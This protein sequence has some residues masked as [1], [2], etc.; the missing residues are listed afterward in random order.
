MSS[1]RATTLVELVAGLAAER[2]E[3]LAVRIERRRRGEDV[4]C[5]ALFA[6]ARVAAA[7]LRAAGLAAGDRVQLLF[8]TDRA[9]I[10]GF[11]GVL[12]AGGVPVPAAP[13]TSLR[14]EDVA[15]RGEALRNQALDA[16][17]SFCLAPGRHRE[18]LQGQL[19]GAGVAVLACEGEGSP[20]PEADLAAPAPEDTAFLQYTSGSTGAPKGVAL[21]HA[22]VLANVAAIED[23]FLP[24]V[25]GELTLSWLPLFHDMGLIGA[26]LVSLYGRVP[27]A[28]AAPA[29]FVRDP[30]WFLKVASRLRATISV[31]PNFA[32]GYAVR[33]VPAE[34]VGEL[35]LAPLRTILNGAE[36][37][38]VEALRRFEEHFA[39]AGLRPGAVRAVYGL[40]ESA[41]AV[42][43]A[44]PGPCVIDRIDADALERD[45][46]AVPAPAGARVRSLVSVGRP[47]ATQEVRIAGPDDDPLGEREVGEVCVRG[48]S[49]MAGYFR[50]PA[51]T[52]K[53]LRA[54]WLR[55]GDFGYLAGGELYLVGREKETIRRYGRSYHPQDIEGQLARLEGVEA[56]LAFGVEVDDDVRVVLVVATRLDAAPA[57]EALE[58]RV[59]HRVGRAFALPVDAVALVPP[60]AIPKSTSGKLRRQACRAFYAHRRGA[61][62]PSG[63]YRVVSAQGVPGDLAEALTRALEDAAARA[64]A[65]E[66]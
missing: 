32:F 64:R 11:F 49:V 66:A 10:E 18:L 53:A 29:D 20:L 12:L 37:I 57:R 9:A 4:S 8:P 16:G 41:L 19:A 17:A 58:Q 15:L 21:T 25:E 27:V 48:P 44:R 22:N 6:G 28:L 24:L 3:A 23:A 46:R 61:R 65:A 2:P 59:R 60:Q 45:G 47:V 52:A 38:D 43:F 7:R 14:A 13:L 1:P 33:R 31:M 39:P 26:L 55:T 56:A 36:P 5:E 34:A 51:A 62:P 54:G 50:Q 63:R 42:T 30:G 35:N 40:A